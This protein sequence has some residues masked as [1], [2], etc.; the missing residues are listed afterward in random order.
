MMKIL[1]ASDNL[2]GALLRP[3][4]ALENIFYNVTS[5]YFAMDV[6]C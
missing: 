3:H 5:F 1:A 2:Y 4:Y 6:V